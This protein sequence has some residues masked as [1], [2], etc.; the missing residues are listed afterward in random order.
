MLVVP[1]GVERDLQSHGIQAHGNEQFSRA[2]RL[3]RPHE[4]LDDGK[5]AVL[6]DGS[7]AWTN[8][9][10]ATPSPEGVAAELA[11]FV[12]DDVLRRVAGPTNRP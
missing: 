2:L 5:A 8:T 11:T 10:T 7:K 6:A 4:P 9:T 12:G 1:E 3:H